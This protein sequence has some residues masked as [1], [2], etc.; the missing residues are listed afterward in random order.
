M[1]WQMLLSRNPPGEA[2]GG[3]QESGARLELEHLA[4]A[5][6]DE[7]ESKVRKKFLMF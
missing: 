2:L 1:T 6:Q 4:V 5:A 3:R 7:I